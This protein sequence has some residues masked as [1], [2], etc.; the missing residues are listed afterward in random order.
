MDVAIDSLCAGPLAKF[1]DLAIGN[2]ISKA[3]K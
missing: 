2:K 3:P 1:F